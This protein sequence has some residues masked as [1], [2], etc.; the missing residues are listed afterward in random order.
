M[1]ASL[2]S[3]ILAS[4]QTRVRTLGSE[5]PHRVGN[6]FGLEAGDLEPLRRLCNFAT[7]LGASGWQLHR[8]GDA[9]RQG[10]TKEGI[11]SRRIR[12]PVA[13]KIALQTAGARAGSAASPTPPGGPSLGTRR[14]STCGI[15]ASRS[16]R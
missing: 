15:S 13:A 3:K 16:I 6:F 7:T 10:Q 1:E 2:G 11:G 12:F 14:T 8:P 9:S 5:R 4:A